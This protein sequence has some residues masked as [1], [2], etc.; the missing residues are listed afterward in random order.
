MGSS[1]SRGSVAMASPEQTS[2]FQL[3]ALDIDKNDVEFSSLD[4][5]VVLVVNVASA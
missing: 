3:S 1:Q 2:F 4:G 5:K